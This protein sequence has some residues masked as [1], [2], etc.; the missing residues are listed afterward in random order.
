MPPDQSQISP[1]KS[2]VKLNQNLHGETVTQK[3]VRLP[4]LHAVGLLLTVKLLELSDSTGLSS[5]PSRVPEA[6]G[7]SECCVNLSAK[8]I[9]I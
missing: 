4:V 9:R 5:H 1:S 8:M 6:G 3:N 7:G 2:V